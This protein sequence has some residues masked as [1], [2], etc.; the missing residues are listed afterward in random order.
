MAYRNF[1]AGV[2]PPQSAVYRNPYREWIGAQIR[3]DFFGYANP[4]DPTRAAEWAWRDACISHVRNGIY[5]EMWVA[6]MLAAAFVER[7]WPTIIRAG[8]AQVPARCRL[9][10]DVG[11][12]LA[13]HAA[14][15]SYEEATEAVHARWDETNGHHWCHTNSNA[16][17]VALG[18]LYGGDNYE[19]TI[20][21]AV[22]PGF[23]T[24]C[25]AATCG[26]LWGAMHG[27]GAL[28][29]KWTAPLRDRVCTGLAGYQDV[30]IRAL[31]EEM[32][33]TGR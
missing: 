33:Q 18:L 32:A 26:S 19:R 22:M 21:R 23:D 20:T 16:Q 3:A 14:G 15:R 6:A 31:A 8:L 1:A 9:A 2:V 7:D 4:G 28:P 11:E 24:D 29:P 25:N 17:A 30:S 12:V 10:E 27:A 5:G 13:L